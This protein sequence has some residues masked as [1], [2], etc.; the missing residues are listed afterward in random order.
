MI[1]D[2]KDVNLKIFIIQYLVSINDVVNKS[3]VSLSV[4]REECD[5]A[6]RVPISAATDWMFE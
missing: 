5:S 6:K 1:L 4:N 3:D 2:H